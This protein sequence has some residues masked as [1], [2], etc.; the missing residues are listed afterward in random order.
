MVEAVSGTTETTLARDTIKH[1]SARSESGDPTR[2]AKVLSHLLTRWTLRPFPFK[3][4]PQ[5][6]KSAGEDAPPSR[7]LTEVNLA[8]EYQFANPVYA[9][10]SAAVAPKVAEYMMEAFEKRV[11]SEVDGPSAGKKTELEGVLR[12]GMGSGQSP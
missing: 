2:N 4:A 5:G 3:P 10:M 6:E 8:I 1:H 11:K 7:E 9:A 12:P